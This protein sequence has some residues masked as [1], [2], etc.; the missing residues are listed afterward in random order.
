MLALTG[1]MGEAANLLKKMKRGDF[2]LDQIRED[3]GRE[4][5]DVAIYLDLLA[6]HLGID[7]GAVTRSKF[8]EVSERIGSLVRLEMSLAG[9]IAQVGVVLVDQTK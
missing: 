1:E 6:D 8:N 3:V 9:L 4:L 2:T 5:A 7:L